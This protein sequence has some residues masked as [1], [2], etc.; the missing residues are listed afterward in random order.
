[1]AL[2][3][4]NIASIINNSIMKNATGE[5]SGTI[6]AED[7]SNLVEVA[8]V[9]N[10]DSVPDMRNALHNLIVGIHNF[11]LEREFE[12]KSY[13]MFRDAISYGGA[14]QRIMDTGFLDAMESHALN[15]TSGTDYTDG[16]FYGDTPNSA[17][18]EETKTYKL[19]YS[20]AEN[21]YGTWFNNAEDLVKWANLVA[22]K[23]R[24]TIKKQVAELEKRILNKV[25]VECLGATTP[26]KVSLLSM[27]NAMEGRTGTDTP[28]LTND[29]K[30]TLTELMKYR[31]EWAYFGSFV[32][33][34]VGKLVDFVKEPTKKYNNGEII[35]YSPS[36]KINAVFLSSFVQ[37]L[38]L[39]TPIE[40]NPMDTPVEFQTVATWQN[41]GADLIPDISTSG[42][43]KVTGATAEADPITYSNIVG[44]VYDVDGCGIV[45]CL[46]KVA[47]K[48]MPEELFYTIFHH[49]GYKYF[50]DG[51]LNSVAITLD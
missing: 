20:V 3:Y 2:T 31:D 15:L 45:E 10:T 33:S 30:W 14:I 46:N 41:L 32:K 18:I 34:T 49:L 38:K 1:M 13:K 25:I 19:A 39:G 9:V 51:R 6:I 27:F 21:F 22:N 11:V 12:T 43:I 26:R 48:D 40:F 23:E 28:T 35:S 44:V 17:L 37:D 29:S 24:N 36:S 7:L 8:K 16:K 50:V 42:V 4:S 5:N 47:S